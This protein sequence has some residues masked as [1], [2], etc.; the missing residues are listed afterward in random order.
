MDDSRFDDIIKNRVG[1]YE[2]QRFDPAALAAMHHQMASLI[3]V[4]WYE[5]YRTEI[6]VGV[7]V[8]VCALLIIW[9][10]WM[11]SSRLENQQLRLL[12]NQAEQLNKLHH[13]LNDLKSIKPDTVRITRI[14]ERP[15]VVYDVMI[16]WLASLESQ[17]ASYQAQS[18]HM[19]NGD[20]EDNVPAL[21]DFTP[22]YA[23]P[24]YERVL[25]NRVIPREL[26]QESERATPRFDY[27]KMKAN[28]QLSV[29]TIRDIE[30]H[31][32]KGVGIRIGPVLESSKGF[33]Q[34]GNSHINLNVGVVG[35]FIV[36][37]A[38]SIETGIKYSKRYYEIDGQDE[39]SKSRLPGTD[40]SIGRL[41]SAEIDS[42]F[43]E[44]PLNVKYRYPLSLKT[45]WIT[46][47]GFS[48]LIYSRQI[49]E[50]NYVYDNGS[51]QNL[52]IASQ[53]ESN[54]IRSSSG[55]MNISIGLS[56]QLRK[57]KTM[58]AALYYQHGLGNMGLE[59]TNVNHIG[60]RG[61]YWFTLR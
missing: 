36:S 51:N 2:E 1:E 39:L 28:R 41:E 13:E 33:Y 3:R 20:G 47:I 40:E 49:F 18:G 12:Q 60:V 7:G 45:H 57:T 27:E 37:P 48:S 55:L 22:S 35:D 21:I 31:Y 50:Y 52:T 15:S 58:E 11:I 53:H 26:T 4:P 42:W 9:S 30:K 24:L 10:Q 25:F 16:K 6:I 5:Q 23:T 17:V 43:L 56:R 46:S 44:V 38:L 32:Q 59:R 54:Q 61:T 14:E 19:V 34:A 29:K 8:V